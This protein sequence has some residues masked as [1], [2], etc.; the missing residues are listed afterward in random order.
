[1]NS[2]G[3]SLDSNTSPWP[4]KQ[5]FSGLSLTHGGWES[6]GRVNWV[7]SCHLF[8]CSETHRDS[9][10]PV[11]VGFLQVDEDISP[12]SAFLVGGNSA[13]HGISNGGEGDCEKL[14]CEGLG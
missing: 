4:L 5:I 8:L 13:D 6:Q 10:P 7:S 3:F 14:G 9:S 11:W 12:C 1:M 2:F